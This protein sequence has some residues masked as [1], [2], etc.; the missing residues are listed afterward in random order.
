M[1]EYSY[2]GGS[3]SIQI[4][5]WNGSSVMILMQEIQSE[6]RFDGIR[7]RVLKRKMLKLVFLTEQ[8]NKRGKQKEEQGSRQA[9]SAPGTRG[10]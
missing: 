10:A 7:R 4:N 2:P 8:I 9:G 1:C 3:D 5:V 6:S